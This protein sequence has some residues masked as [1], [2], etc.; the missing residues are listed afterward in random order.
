M[1][2]QTPERL[3]ALWK[4]GRDK[5]R[6]FFAVL[7]DVRQEV[8]DD[9]LADWCRLELAIGISVISNI[10]N[11]LTSTEAATVKFALSEAKRA[12]RDKLRIE[13][14]G[15]K[16]PIRTKST[17]V[18]K[19]NNDKMATARKIVRPLVEQNIKKI[20]AR[21]LAKEHGISHVTFETAIAIERAIKAE[22]T[23]K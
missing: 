4:S 22:Y 16:N 14:Q 20:G 17:H 23:I 13:K 1:E 3:R 15:I 10:A 5:Y 2:P 7:N 18:V 8:G 9:A 6:S 19:T 21:K 11:V 12:E